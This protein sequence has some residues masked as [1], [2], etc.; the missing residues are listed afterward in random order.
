MGK[1]LESQNELRFALE[2]VPIVIGGTT[3]GD[4]ESILA[5][6]PSFSD[7]AIV[8]LVSEYPQNKAEEL[9]ENIQ[10][11]KFGYSLTFEERI[12]ESC[13][14]VCMTPQRLLQDA[15]VDPLL[16]KYNLIVIEE[17]QQRLMWVDVLIGVL[18]RVLKKRPQLKVL[19]HASI[20]SQSVDEIVKFL[21]AQVLVVNEQTSAYA[22][23][24]YLNQPVPDY[25]EQCSET[26][27]K[28]V[29][30][31]TV[32]GDIVV[33]GLSKTA[34]NHVKQVL[35]NASEAPTYYIFEHY[36]ELSRESKKALFEFDDKIRI[37]LSST[38]SAELDSEMRTKL[39]I[40]FVIDT[41]FMQSRWYDYRT[42]QWSIVNHPISKP[43][44][45]LRRSLA[46]YKCYRLY[47]EMS[48]RSMMST[49]EIPQIL[50]YRLVEPF[51]LIMSLGFHD[52]VRSFP[53]VTSPTSEAVAASLHDLRLLDA[54]SVDG[55]LTRNGTIMGE[56]PLG[57]YMGRAVAL[58]LSAGCLDEMLW[59]AAGVAVGGLSSLLFR[60]SAWV[61][62]EEAELEHAK[63]MVS[64]GDYLT[65]LNIISS[66]NAGPQTSRWA[67]THF[68][69]YRAL[70]NARDAYE[71]LRAV[72]E[73]SNLYS[74]NDFTSY[75]G[76][77]LSNVCS[78]LQQCLAKSYFLQVARYSD[79]KWL[80][81]ATETPV[82]A[83]PD[84]SSVMSTQWYAKSDPPTHWAVYEE[85]IQSGGN[86]YLKGLNHINRVDI[87]A[88]GYYHQSSS[89]SV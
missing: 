43:M 84:S 57:L 5:Q 23:T 29:R 15:L 83:I 80:V 25:I 34:Q 31:E 2:R 19:L 66:F 46:E 7:G 69:N 59:V 16:S 20:M 74:N 12:D 44:A 77:N 33:V 27:L 18:K 10:D 76:S 30:G 62:R 50:H 87:M 22:D 79:G 21:G 58:S 37:V 9:E 88:T 70:L 81:M 36:W 6:K 63:F 39:S 35:E 56:L 45:E 89:L 72:I 55:K 24:L 85:L 61:Q 38:T 78:D 71:H 73:R 26:V 1:L 42:R 75:H 28:I 8:A 11:C 52:V 60:P 41:G 68:L 53:F 64:E 51:L 4:V 3:C 49:S 86:L 65:I 47:T 48:A 17:V 40:K 67:V 13:M 82:E 54:I 32:K 14:I